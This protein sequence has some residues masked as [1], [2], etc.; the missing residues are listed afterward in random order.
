MASDRFARI[1]SLY[2]AALGRSA[3][4]RDAFLT[5]AC[6]GDDTLRREVES[7]LAEQTAGSH[8]LNSPT[9]TSTE[10][11]STRARPSLVG[12]RLGPYEITAPLGAGGMGEVYK[13]RN[14]KL[15]RSPPTRG[16]WRASGAK[17]ARSPRST[18]RTSA[19]STGSRRS[20]ASPF[21]FSNWRRATRSPIGSRA[22][23][24][25]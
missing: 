11:G 12:R 19:P 20:T 16:A 18:T 17:H 9:L 13:A 8:I 21:S 25:S 10:A 7:L 3:A 15:R 6:A 2:H 23:P 5:D 22:V 1:E 4:D 14:S 24:C